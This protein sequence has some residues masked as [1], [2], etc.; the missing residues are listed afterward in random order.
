[1]D[2]GAVTV[3]AIPVGVTNTHTLTASNLSEAS[4]VLTATDSLY[5]NGYGIYS[6]HG[7]KC[8]TISNLDTTVFAKGIKAPAAEIPKLYGLV[9]M[10]D[11]LY[12]ANG[13]N[14]SKGLFAVGLATANTGVVYAKATTGELGAQNIAAGTITMGSATTGLAA[15]VITQASSA[16]TIS[17]SVAL[18]NLTLSQG[19]TGYPALRMYGPNAKATAATEYPLY[20]GSN[21][22][23]ASNP[24]ALEVSVTG[25]A[26]IANRSINLQTLDVNSANGGI[27]KLQ[28]SGGSI[29]TANN[30]AFTVAGK[31]N[32]YKDSNG[33]Y[34]LVGVTT[35][36]AL[37]TTDQGT[38]P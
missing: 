33:H 19:T 36:G 32:E 10:N 1:M 2:S 4:N 30:I 17:A 14:T 28:M 27:L 3:G 29:Q 24:F 23:W 8:A 21:D 12:V 38:S 16:V 13:I 6:T 11:S 20:I 7:F 9:T 34:W 18:P 22:A 31:G 5:L 25:A 35:L 26:A 15:S 37:T